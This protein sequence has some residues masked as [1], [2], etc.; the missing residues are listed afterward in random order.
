[1]LRSGLPDVCDPTTV[2]VTISSLSTVTSYQ[3]PAQTVYVTLPCSS[4]IESNTPTT[5]LTRVNTLASTTYLQV[6]TVYLTA[7]GAAST[8]LAEA[9][10]TTKAPHQVTITET[11]V[12]VVTNVQLTP[13]HSGGSLTYSETAA[14]NGLLT[15]VVEN[16]TTY[17]LNGQTP[18]P[19]ESYV[20]ET[21][22]VTAVPIASAASSS[23]TSIVTLHTTLYSTQEFTITE[24]LSTPSPTN[25]ASVY[26]GTGSSF[27]GIAAGGWNATSTTRSALKTGAVAYPTTRSLLSLMT[28]DPSFNLTTTY[29]IVSSTSLA[30]QAGF[31]A[32][33]T[34]SAAGSTSSATGAL[35]SPVPPYAN[36][37]LAQ[38][39]PASIGLGPV[40]SSASGTAVSA[41]SGPFPTGYSSTP[42]QL[43]NSTAI[44][45]SYA[46]GVPMS[47]TQSMTNA[48]QSSTSAASTVSATPSTC[49]EVGDFTLNVSDG[50]HL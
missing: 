27:T 43:A 26:A 38:S 12:L 2:F 32:V 28:Q 42:S 49:G 23:D 20:V 29:S 6:D 34:S 45:S 9:A 10:A 40:T 19:S 21:S 7:P 4:D 31:N 22:V 16:G 36:I 46:T 39:S 13:L 8:V 48:T 15:F 5:T 41:A 44:A 24:T 50:R 30:A 14:P 17:W 25:S 35:T 3:A 37:T 47:S 1:M 18:A 33:T 11:T